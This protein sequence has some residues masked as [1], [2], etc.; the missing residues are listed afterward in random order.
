MECYRVLLVD[1]EEEIRAGI[2]RK[3]D[4]DSLGFTLAGEADNGEEALELA[5]LVRPDVVLTDI[6]MPFMDGL[7]LCRRLKRVLPAAKT[8]V[9]SGFDDFE[10]ARKAVGMGVSEYIMKPI[11][12]QEMSGVL[13]RLKDQLDQQQAERRDMESL[14]R[15]YEESLPVLRELFIPGCWTARS[16]RSRS[17]TGRPDMRSRCRMGPGQWLCLMWTVWR[18]QSS[19]TSCCSSP[20]RAF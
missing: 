4:W 7:E 12:A 2:S 16:G 14:R 8:V 19:G 18:M 10:Y 20:C 17:G 3:I 11:N 5:E 6:K 15:R 9:F 1:D 13:L